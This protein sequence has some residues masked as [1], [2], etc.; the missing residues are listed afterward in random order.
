MNAD[1]LNLSLLE[2]EEIA[3]ILSRR[4]NEIAGYISDYGCE[5]YP[6]KP[7]GQFTMPASVEYAC[8]LEMKRLRAL[9]AKIKPPA[10]SD[11]DE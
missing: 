8:S 7:V 4:A 10:A 1:T 11:E 3:T 2:R 9:E 5:G 6:K